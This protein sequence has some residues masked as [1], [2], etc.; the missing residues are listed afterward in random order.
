MSSLNPF[1]EVEV[2]HI[3]GNIERIDTSIKTVCI[4]IFDKILLNI[5]KRIL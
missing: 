2:S 1:N 4:E 3:K 5:Y